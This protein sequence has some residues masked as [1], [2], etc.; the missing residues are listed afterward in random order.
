MI[1]KLTLLLFSIFCY[2]L[3]FSQGMSVENS[4][5]LNA[6]FS[7]HMVLQQSANVSFWGTYTPNETLSVTGSWGS[8]STTIVDSNGHWKLDLETPEAGGPF[9]VEIQTKFHKKSLVNIMIG[10]VWLASGQSNMEMTLRGWPPNDIIDNSEEEIQKADYA[11]VRMFTVQKQLSLNPRGTFKGS[12]KVSSPE[13]AG[14]FSASAYFFARR[15]HKTLK[16]PIGIIHSSWGGTPVEAWTSNEQVKK[17]G[18]FD[19]I[20]NTISSVDPQKETSDWFSKWKSI[21]IPVGDKQ[22]DQ[23]VVYDSEFK[24]VDYDDS[25]WNQVYLPGQFD[26]TTQVDFDGVMWFRKTVHIRDLRSDYTLE[27][28]AIDDMDLIYVNGN[29]VGGFAGASYS[30]SKRAYKVSKRLLNKGANT[31]AIRAIDIGGPGTFKG[32]MLLSSDSGSKISLTGYWSYRMAAEIYKGKLYLYGTEHLNL[33]DK[34]AIFKVNPKLPT[35]LFNAMI[36]PLIP[37]TIKGAIWYQGEEN[38]GRAEQYKQLFPAMIS[39]W[40][41]RWNY[42]FPFYFVQ[43]APFQYPREKKTA[44]DQSQKLREA[45][46]STLNTINTGMVV[47]MDI[48]NFNNI[49]PSN[50]QAVGKRLAGLALANEYGKQLVASGPLFKSIK[51]RGEILVV[52][53]DEIG[54][55]LISKGALRGFEIA[56]LDM[57]YKVAEANI[58]N[59]TIELSASTVS[60]PKYAR[61]GWSDQ[62]V[63]CLF[64]R[65][66]LPASSF[67]SE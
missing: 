33:K 57:I 16:V 25:Q 61:Y 55:G 66:G 19:R 6:L 43:I 15:L 23:L 67:T 60:N 22:W 58:I 42:D 41:E 8:K 14:E 21:A 50:K 54:S 18:D 51:R 39:D 1:N 64:N 7:D 56:G 11:E 37:Y 12:W 3:S 9:T 24:Q 49:H 36:H 20:L 10:E 65:E 52:N 28:E 44:L 5:Q 35:V 48:G 46:R 59:N 40:R 17:T 2:T 26:A 27:I 45:Q 38:V 32:P 30:N 62:A 34:A 4:L 53:F 13:T 31:I 47:T 29:K 63:P